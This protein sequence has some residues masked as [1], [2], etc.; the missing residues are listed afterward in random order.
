M[1]NIFKHL[2]QDVYVI[3][4]VHG[5]FDLLEDYVKERDFLNNC[6]LIV[7]GDCGFGFKPL[8]A[9]IWHMEI[10]NFTLSLKNII[11]YFIRGNH[12]DPSYFSNMKIN[13]SNIKTIPDYSIIEVGNE[14]I[15]CIGGGVSIDR[16]YRKNKDNDRKEIYDS[17]EPKI[18]FFPSYWENE[19]PNYNEEKLH[20]IHES[21][22]ILN[23]VIT[24]TSP[25]FCFK[26]GIQ[27]LEKWIENDDTLLDDLHKERDI[28]SN[29]YDNLVEN[30]HPIKKW[31]YGH[32]HKHHEENINS[33]HFITLFNIEI[34]LDVYHL[35]NENMF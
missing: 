12:D 28:M 24:H 5:K 23:Y 35:N 34:I 27:G 29:I 31:I 32:F 6:I 14:N 20:E 13:F 4:D 21:G 19:L 11:L 9:Y 25:S 15:L 26:Y 10:L 8:H 22:I 17:I 33:I 30:K 7:A 3:G 2:K 1:I 18:D 16:V